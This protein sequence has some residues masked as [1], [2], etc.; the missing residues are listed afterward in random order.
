MGDLTKGTQA[1]L[2]PV[3]SVLI[4]PIICSEN[5]F[6]NL[7]RRFVRKGGEVIV[8]QT[9]DAWYLDS[10]AAMQH[11]TMNI[12]RAIENRRVVVVSGNTGVSGIIEP[13]GRI[14]G[15]MSQHRRAFLSGTVSPSR[16][17]TFYTKFGDWFALLCVFYALL[18]L[19]TKF[20]YLLPQNILRF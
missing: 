9:N 20:K 16:V 19:V 8:S 14:S 6:G 5:F 4:S 3:K 11:F 15:Q 12:F 13:N 10:S 18:V 2:L 1:D 7:V 17:I